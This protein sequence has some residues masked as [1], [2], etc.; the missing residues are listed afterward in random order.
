[1]IPGSFALTISIKKTEVLVQDTPTTPVITINESQLAVVHNF[2]YLGS[3][4]SD[5]LSL[6]QEINARIGK[7][8]T[9]MSKI[10]KRVWDNKNLTLK[11]KLKVY[12]ACVLSTLLY[13]SE[14]WSTY[15][16]QESKLNAFHMRCLRRLLN[17][18]WK[19]RVPN[20]EV[21]SKANTTNIHTMLTER[22]LRWLGH[23][24]H[25]MGPVVF[26]MTCYTDS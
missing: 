15:T 20:T 19:D 14:S 3:T 13:G 8:A 21:L 17:I 1:M 2:K 9:V 26:Q 23:V 5:N 25:R 12:Q 10:N 24:N 22:R 18:S 7:A 6:D 16:R 4:I 11:T